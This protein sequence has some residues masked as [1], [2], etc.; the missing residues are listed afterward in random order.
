MQNLLEKIYLTNDLSNEEITYLLEN[1]THEDREVLNNYALKTKQA[2]YGNKVYLRGLIEFSNICRQ[3]CLYCGI[4]ASNAKV[5]RYRLTPEEIL[6]CCDQGYELGY[7]TFVLQ[8]GEDLWYTEEILS[9]LIQEIK[10][11]YPEVA[12]TLSIGE[13]RVGTYQRLFTAGADR[14]LMRHETASK[15]LYEKLHPMMSFEERRTCLSSLKEIGY[16]VGA[17]F[18][19]GLPGQTFADLAEDLRY[20]KE[21]CPDMIGIGPFIPHS[22]TPLGAEKGG[23]LKDTLVM[24]ALARLLIPESLIP[25]TTA[26]GTLHPQGRELALKAGANVVMP[27]ITPTSVRKQYA[28]YENKICGDD[29][30]ED[31]RYCIERRI[32]SAGFEVDLGRG[33]SWRFIEV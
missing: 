14:F 17:G 9:S 33:D 32:Q 16:Q 27:I 21:L 23:T 29:H 1:I 12:I 18:M 24:V 2:Y 19:V 20:L 3:D 30:P 28:L 13:R 10:R 6:G 5:K 8:S 4:R 7:R 26:L 15:E 31:C 22:E 25:A 11:R